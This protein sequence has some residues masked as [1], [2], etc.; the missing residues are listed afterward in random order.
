MESERASSR[1]TRRISARVLG[2]LHPGTVSVFIHAD[3]ATNGIGARIT[4]VDEH[5]FSV[6]LITPG[7]SVDLLVLES[8]D[9][10][11]VVG[12]VAS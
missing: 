7:R 9:G 3:D 10:E 2:R 8:V 5:L 11:R 4:T 6:D 1:R 12:V